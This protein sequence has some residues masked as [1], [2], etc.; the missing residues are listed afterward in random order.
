[1][2]RFVLLRLYVKGEA[3][4]HT[5]V[6]PVPRWKDYCLREKGKMTE[7]EMKAKYLITT[8]TKRECVELQKA[9]GRLTKGD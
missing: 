5:I 1:M 7:A 4:K 6:W 3:T 8:G 2:S 9:F